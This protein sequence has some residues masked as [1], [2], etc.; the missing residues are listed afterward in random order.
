MATTSWSGSRLDAEPRLVARGHLA[1]QVVHAVRHAVAVVPRVAGRLAELVDD[2]VLGRVGRVAHAQVDD[3]DARRPLAVLQLVDP[4]E[5][6]G[7]QVPD[8][9]SDLEVVALDRLMLLRARVGLGINH[10]RHRPRPAQ[11]ISGSV[12]PRRAWPIA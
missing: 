7:G 5:Q 6:V 8:P 12:G 11:R 1:A 9:G 10:R 2:P 4:A 3:V